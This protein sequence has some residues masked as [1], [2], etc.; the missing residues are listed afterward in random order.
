LGVTNAGRLAAITNYRSADRQ[1]ETATSRGHLVAQF[2]ASDL[3][4]HAFMADLANTFGS[5]NPFNLTLYDGQTLLGFE[6]RVTHGR[7]V[8]LAPGLGG[9]SNADFNTPWFKQ[10]RLQTDLAHLLASDAYDDE[11]L[12]DLLLNDERAPLDQ[13]PNTG[14][15]F[16]RELALSA[17]F[18]RLGHY[19][20]R[21]SSVVRIR[22]DGV[23]FSE[24]GFDAQT[25]THQA[26]HWI[27]RIAATPL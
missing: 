1:R 17:P 2:L 21:A 6:G 3:S 20:T 4:S 5:Y 22:T 16:D 11:A 15:P 8:T 25:P 13:L 18:V 7:V 27:P 24:R 9:V 23:V 10:T 12:L 19:G 14:V 26:T